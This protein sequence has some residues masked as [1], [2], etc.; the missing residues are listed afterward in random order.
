MV[1]VKATKDSEAGVIPSEQ[2]LADMGRYNEE[3]VK[4]GVMT[5]GEGLLSSGKGARVRFSG[6]GR[7][8]VPGPFPETEQLVAGFWL[9]KVGSLQEAID[10]VKK[11]PNPMLTDSEIE[12]RQIA[13]FED[14]GENLTPD[15]QEQERRLR[16]E[17]ERL[18]GGT[19]TTG[20]P[21]TGKA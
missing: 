7:T 5:G 6:A 4:A 10:W 18:A 20:T 3:L 15:L 9:F 19:T 14:F 1:I 11:C 12:I 21:T 17:T 8:V 2:L 16:E 13:E